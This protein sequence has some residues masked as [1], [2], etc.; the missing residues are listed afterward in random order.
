METNRF[1]WET[2]RAVIG[3]GNYSERVANDVVDL[4]VL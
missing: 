4:N 3:F 1:E 2:E